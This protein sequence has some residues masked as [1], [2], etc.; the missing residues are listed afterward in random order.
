MMR[1]ATQ[2]AMERSFAGI[3]EREGR[4]W[5][6]E[7]S[8]HLPWCFWDELSTNGWTPHGWMTE[9]A[10]ELKWEQVYKQ[11]VHVLEPLSINPSDWLQPYCCY[12]NTVIF[13]LRG[14]CTKL[15]ECTDPPRTWPRISFVCRDGLFYEVTG[16]GVVHVFGKWQHE[17]YARKNT[18]LARHFNKQCDELCWFCRVLDLKNAERTE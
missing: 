8:R 12:H 15:A 14:T 16:G 17:W 5:S 18:D 10:R 11:C 4:K 2:A 6:A 1:S 9:W 13:Y 7:I 3:I